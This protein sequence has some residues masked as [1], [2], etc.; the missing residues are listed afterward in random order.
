MELVTIS[1]ATKM[2]NTTTRTLRYYEEIGLITSKR[3]VDYAYRVYD[4]TTIRRL[5]AI[6]ILRK[7]TIPLDRIQI[8]LDNNETMMAVK[9]FNERLMIIDDE[10]DALETIKTLI[11]SFI[12]KLS[13]NVE[14]AIDKHLLSDSALEIIDSL[15]PLNKLKK[16]KKTMSDLNDA[17]KIVEKVKDIRIVYLPPATV[18]SSHYVGENPEENAESALREFVHNNKLYDIKPDF[19]MYGFNNP[20]VDENGKYG[21]EFWVTIP[22]DL[23]VE[24][25]LTKKQFQGGL[26]AAHCIKMGDFHEWQPFDQSVQQ[27]KK[28]MVEEREPLGMCGSLEEHLNAYTYYK[29]D[30]TDEFFQLDLLIPVKSIEK[31]KHLT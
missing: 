31:E 2:F 19:R 10:I 1:Q 15:A 18:A 25:P 11:E 27:D 29:N 8:I 20:N 24:H 17:S 3:I 14:L 12:V 16:E 13:K 28:Y 5:H 7:L 23:E 21:Y 6:F 4:Q 22:D 26:Y 30:L 9:V